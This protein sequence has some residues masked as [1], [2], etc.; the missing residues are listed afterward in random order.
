[1]AEGG[2]GTNGTGKKPAKP[3]APSGPFT[4]TNRFKVLPEAVA[5]FE[6]TWREREEAMRSFPG[7]QGF[8]L[9]RDGDNFAASSTWAT[10]P[11]WEAWNLS[12]VCRRS[13]LPLG[14]WQYVPAK[15][16]GFPED[17]V[18]LLDYDEPVNAK[19]P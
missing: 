11:E 18:F 1:M 10:I 2:N 3:A 9:S 12:P 19:Y 16:E 14:V 6:A 17:F 5:L 4:N 7:F 13:H 8:K 15:G